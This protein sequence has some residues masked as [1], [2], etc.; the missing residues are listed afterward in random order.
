[1]T[2]IKDTVLRAL[3]LLA[4]VV[5]LGG[6][7]TD[8]EFRGEGTEPQMVLYTVLTAH[9]TP[10]VHLSSS[11]FILDN[12]IPHRDIANANIRL[13]VDDQYVETLS[14]GTMV[15]QVGTPTGDYLYFGK[16]ICKSG[17]RITLV[18]TAPK[19][20][21]EVRGET[22]IPPVTNVE[23]VTAGEDA[24]NSTDYI[25]EGSVYYRFEDPQPE[26]E[27]YFWI[28]GEMVV[29]PD[30]QMPTHTYEYP[31]DY[32]DIAF[33]SGDAEGFI[34]DTF[35]AGTG[36]YV[37]FDDSDMAERGFCVYKMDYHTPSEFFAE[38]VFKLESYVIDTHLYSYLR[39]LELASS[40][41]MFGEPV[42][43][44]TNVE[45]GIGLVGSR[46]V[47]L[48]NELPYLSALDH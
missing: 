39:S 38:T 21:G 8:V 17:E 36:P 12:G 2:R 31:Y 42:Q 43:V 15:D 34:E 9:T 19:F 18:A 40:S 10:T 45:G 32:S 28:H 41:T 11:T 3:A 47:L 27:N 25:T 16:H 37:Y 26:V 33:S 23:F 44:Y 14:C 35:D 20:K 30:P 22:V 6:C 13:Y 24:A 48:K 29:T 46:S 1:M 7:E 4:S 5:M